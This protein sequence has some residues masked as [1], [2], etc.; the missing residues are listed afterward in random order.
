MAGTQ[1]ACIHSC[2][3]RLYLVLAALIGVLLVS[4]KVTEIKE[5]AA[6]RIGVAFTEDVCSESLD[7]RMLLLISSDDSREPR[8]QISYS[9]PNTQLIYG[10]DVEGLKPGEPAWFDK[11]VFGYPVKSIAGIPPGEYWVQA[12]LHRYETFNRSDGHVLKLPMDRGE[13]QHWNRAPG[14]LYSTPQKIRIDPHSNEVI[15]I[16][17][18]REI[19]PISPPED[20]KYIKHIRIQSERLTEFWG[21]PMHL[22]AVLLLPEGFDEHPDAR[23]PVA[24]NHGH[25]PYTFSE[26]RETPPE[27]GL[28]GYQK[29][30]A[31]NRYQL[32]KDWT[33]PDFPRVIIAKIQHANPYYDDSYA[34]NSANLGPYGD[35]IMYELIPYIEEKFRGIG[36][37]WAR[38]LYGGSTGGWESFA[39]QVFYPDE[40]N[41]TWALCPDM[42]DFHAYTSVNIYDDK[43]AYYI[44]SPWKRTPRPGA[45]N[46][47]GALSCI[48]EEPNYLELVLGSKGRSGGQL[49]IFQAVFGP[50]GED[51]YPKP[52]WDKM[53]GE[54]DHSV[55]EYWRE[56]Y[57]MHHILKRDWS[58]LGPKLEGKLHIYVGDMDTHYLN[59]A[60]YMIEEFLES[61]TNPYYNG[62]VEYGDRAEHCW[63]GDHENPN[64]VARFTVIQRFVPQ[65][66]KRMLETAPDGADVSSWRY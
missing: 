26:F 15:R 31:E 8:F 14:N 60:V 65:M 22:G 40:F 44:D 27:P 35:A 34:V 42:L 3:R 49:D 30:T 29:T 38:A 25:F 20:T 33:S 55:A 58:K 46:Y 62:V 7:G 24:I 1:M 63:T 6:L 32:Y 19:P 51:G 48:S 66:V 47:L 45:R 57:D 61:T 21:R 37:G 13:G 10:V 36:S 16:T 41:G 4:C 28:S 52:I 50:V 18:D 43:N 53:T 5:D 9:N 64:S 17:L 12:L 39:V 56:H 2:R 11:S 54:I 59:N 23:Y